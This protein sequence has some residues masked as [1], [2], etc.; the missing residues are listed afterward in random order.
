[1]LQGEFSRNIKSELISPTSFVDI[2]GSETS[3]DQMVQHGENSHQQDPK[4]LSKKL[5]YEEI[6]SRK[7]KSD[8]PSSTEP[9]AFVIPKQYTTAMSSNTGSQYEMNRLNTN[10]PYM[11]DMYDQ[12][13]GMHIYDDYSE[14]F[15]TAFKPKTNVE[16]YPTTMQ[17]SYTF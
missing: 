14:K 4:I 11:I 9:D 6:R 17:P 1:M 16:T 13:R 3:D 10:D 5:K 2:P 12:L 8:S 15:P 7:S